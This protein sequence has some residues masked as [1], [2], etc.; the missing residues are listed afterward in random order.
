MLYALAMAYDKD[1]ICA[2]YFSVWIL[3]NADLLEAAICS[4][5][6]DHLQI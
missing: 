1:R 3:P 2:G 6:L 5:K 4:I